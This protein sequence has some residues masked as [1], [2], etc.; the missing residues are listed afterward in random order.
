MKKYVLERLLRSLV[1]IFLVTTIAYVL[2]FSLVPRKNIFID[3]PLISKLKGKP[4]DLLD[5]QNLQYDKSGYIEYKR[6]QDICSTT[7]GSEDYNL[8][9]SENTNVDNKVVQEF[10]NNNKGNWQ[11]NTMP[12]SGRVYLTREIGNFERVA[13][14]YKNLFVIDHP[15]KIQD[16]SNPDLA[17]GIGMSFASNQGL[18]AL[19]C[20]G[21]ENKSLL[22]I[23]GSFPFIHQNVVKLDLGLSYPQYERI[24]V[25]KVMTNKQG[26]PVVSPVEFETGVKSNSPLNLKKCTYKTTDSMDKMDNERFLDNYANCEQVL[27]APSMMNISLMTGTIAVLFA[28]AVGVPL[29]VGM[30]RKKGLLPDKIGMA[31]I[32]IMISVPSLAFIYFFRFFGNKLFGLPV[33]FPVLGATNIKSYILPTVILGMLSISGLM[34]WVRRYMI[35]QQ[36]ADYV[37]FAKAKGLSNKE[38]SQR[39]IFRNAIIPITN[40]IPISIIG[41]IQGATITETV[42]AMSG[43][44]KLLPEAIKGHNNAMVIG[45]LLIFTTLS[46]FAVFLGDIIL[47]KVDPRISL[48]TKGGS[49]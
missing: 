6:I 8:C 15:W 14:F 16:E 35:D 12:E 4:D 33:L 11:V 2:I 5:Y 46:V 42:F 3:D 24:P 10:I 37:K 32:T 26:S 1:S 25:T 29:G 31:A 23:D 30:A 13:K 43:M 18:A 20:S 21:C 41:A 7:E 17:R 9:M 40:G 27:E 22:Y 44:G 49:N 48:D 38:I 45:L 47:T 34:I 36:S 19:T 39:H 28:Y